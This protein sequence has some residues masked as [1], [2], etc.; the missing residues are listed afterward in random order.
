MCI[1][2]KCNSGKDGEVGLRLGR[3]GSASFCR[4]LVNGGT[5]TLHER[6]YSVVIVSCQCSGCSQNYVASSGA[7]SVLGDADGFGCYLGS[8]IFLWR[9]LTSAKSSTPSDGD[10]LKVLIF[11]SWC[12]N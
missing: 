8:N 11:I 3:E 5:M 1:E 10:V 2:Q 12:C 7:P 4:R 6:V 9:C